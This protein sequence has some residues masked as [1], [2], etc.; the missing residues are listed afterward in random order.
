MSVNIAAIALF[1]NPP[2]D[3]V[4]IALHRAV[5]GSTMEAIA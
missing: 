4:L 1:T 5:D 2:I 3:F